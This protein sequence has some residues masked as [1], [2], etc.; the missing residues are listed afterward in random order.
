M[1]WK[2]LN[3]QLNPCCLLNSFQTWLDP[4]SRVSAMYICSPEV[5]CWSVM[6]CVT[7][8][9]AGYGFIKSG[10]Q[11]RLSL[12]LAEPPPLPR[13]RSKEASLLAKLLEP[14]LLLPPEFDLRTWQPWTVTAAGNCNSKELLPSIWI[15][16][17]GMPT[18]GWINRVLLVSNSTTSAAWGLRDG[19]RCQ[20]DFNRVSLVL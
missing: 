11:S 6:Y 19:V 18:H 15:D 14:N 4:F 10:S 3:N 13:D 1:T 7:K 2:V 5:L 17:N 8:C 12:L 16:D 9:E 20:H